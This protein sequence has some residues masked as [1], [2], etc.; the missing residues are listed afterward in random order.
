MAAAASL[1]LSITTTPVPLDCPVVWSMLMS[2]RCTLPAARKR[3][4][5]SCQPMLGL[6]CVG[7]YPHNVSVALFAQFSSASKL[8]RVTLT[9]VT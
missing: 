4:L 2:A 9:P 1:L 6:I 3:S 7:W 5:R 8:G